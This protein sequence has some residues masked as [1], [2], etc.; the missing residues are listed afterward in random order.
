M[1]VNDHCDP[2][3]LNGLSLAEDDYRGTF[4]V[5][6]WEIEMKAKDIDWMALIESGKIKRSFDHVQHLFMAMADVAKFQGRRGIFGADKGEKY[7][8][9]FVD[10]LIPQLKIMLEDRLINYSDDPDDICDKIQI[11][12]ILFYKVFPN[13]PDALQFSTS[14]FGENKVIASTIVGQLLGKLF[15]W[16]TFNYNG[17]TY[18]GEGKYNRRDG[19]AIVTWPNG[20][21]YV[22][23]WKEDKRDGQGTNTSPD[24]DKYVGEWKDDNRD[25][26]GTFTTPNGEKYV[27]EWKDNKRD[28]LGTFTTP[29]GEKY[30]GGWK[31]NNRDGQGINTWPDGDKYVGEFKDGKR[32]GQGTFTTPNGDKYVGEWKDDNRDGQG[33][34]T[35][36]NG[37]KYVGEFKDDKFVQGTIIWP[38]DD[39]HVGQFENNND[40]ENEAIVAYENADFATALRLW[41]LLADQGNAAAQFYLGLMYAKGDGVAKDYKTAVKW[42]TRAAEQGNADAQSNLGIMFENGSGVAQDYVKAHMWFNIAAIDGSSKTVAS[43]RDRIAKKM[44]PAQIEKAQ[45]AASRCIKQKFKNCD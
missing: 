10:L 39:K 38:D 29:N 14:F 18:I 27:G 7:F 34:F 25:G 26:Q 5:E 41:T 40:F 30:V 31:D 6:A 12:N 19:H 8:N 43:K 3:F 22:G 23:K 17:I 36:P 33:T 28:G 44:T 9:K 45:E 35:T 42:Y 24:G 20:E 2:P 13:W 32:D 4:L 37:E 16:R 15:G 21:K 11:M 1:N